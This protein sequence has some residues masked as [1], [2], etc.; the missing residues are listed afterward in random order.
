MDTG[1]H[2]SLHT[3]CHH[4]IVY[5][6]FNLKVHYPP[7]Y[8]REVWRFQKADINLIRRA[9]NQFNW[10]GDFFNLNINEM[11]PVFNA[12]IKNIMANFIHMRQSSVMIEIPHGLTIE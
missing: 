11:V 2:P 12:T 7:P 4:Q 5:A 10:E 1:I 6:K 9:M 8:K 3:S